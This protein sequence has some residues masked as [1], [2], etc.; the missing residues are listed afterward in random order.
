MLYEQHYNFCLVATD[1]LFLCGRHRCVLTKQME[2]IIQCRPEAGSIEVLN[3]HLHT[4]LY[5]M[6][7]WIMQHTSLTPSVARHAAY[8]EH[9][10]MY[11]GPCIDMTPP[12]LEVDV[13]NRRHP[14]YLAAAALSRRVGLKRM[15]EMA[16]CAEKEKEH[17]TSTMDTR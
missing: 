4:S 13:L 17:G 15:V 11:A 14:G 5:Y 12:P 8:F 2:V 6:H 9:A 10:P 3:T 1:P 16:H 7:L